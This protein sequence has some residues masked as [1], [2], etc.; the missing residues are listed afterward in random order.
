MHNNYYFKQIR[1]G[2]ETFFFQNK[3]KDKVKYD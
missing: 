1:I 2:F 3:N